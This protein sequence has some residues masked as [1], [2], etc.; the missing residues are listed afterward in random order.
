MAKKSKDRT[1]ER[2]EAAQSKAVRFLR[3]V[4]GNDA[5]AGEI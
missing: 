3:D 4:V 5:K 2:V 1:R